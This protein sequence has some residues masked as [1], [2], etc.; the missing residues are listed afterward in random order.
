MP[1]N[2]IVLEGL[3]GS[4]KS[5]QAPLLAEQ[6]RKNGTRVREVSFP[7]YDQPSGAVIQQY[8]SGSMGN[9]SDVNVYAASAFYAIDRY[10]SF[11]TDWQKE[12]EQENTIL[13]A[14][15]TTS[16][17]IHQMSK[18]PASEWDGYLSWLCEFE[19][20]KLRI[21]EPDLVL[22]LDMPLAVSQALMEQRYQAT[23]GKRDIHEENLQYLARCRDAADYAAKRFGWKVIP[24]ANG[25]TPCPVEEISSRLYAGVT[26]FINTKRTEQ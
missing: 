8:L 21:P 12:Y 19:F 26:D 7:C 3:D 13:A 23:G 10:V 17:M 25:N 1:G 11:H 20:R 22:F 24:C 15:Y 4:G 6:M 5:T 18:L 2:L 16:N 9:L 14:R